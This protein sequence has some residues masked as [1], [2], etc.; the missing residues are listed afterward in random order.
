MTFVFFFYFE[1]DAK[2]LTIKLTINR[3]QQKRSTAIINAKSVFLAALLRFSV[4]TKTK[5]KT[6]KIVQIQLR[7]RVYRK[8]NQTCIDLLA[9]YLYLCQALDFIVSKKIFVRLVFG[10]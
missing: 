1:N 8:L 4:Y 6:K 7:R 9:F 5:K 3:Q 10:K 2:K